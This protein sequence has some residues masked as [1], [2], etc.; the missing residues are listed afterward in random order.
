MVVRLV[1]MFTTY[2]THGHRQIDRKEET[3]LHN[4]HLTIFLGVCL[5]F[6]PIQLFIN[7]G[8]FVFLL[9]VLYAIFLRRLGM[10]TSTSV[11][12]WIERAMWFCLGFCPS[13]G[14]LGSKLLDLLQ[15]YSHSV[16]ERAAW[17]DKLW[18]NKINKTL[19]QVLSIQVSCK[20]LPW[21]ETLFWVMIRL[22]LQNR[23]KL[24]RE[25]IDI[26]TKP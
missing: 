23:A 7:C 21:I 18:Y 10:K 20:F 2:L 14:T 24:K 17:D 9:H 26:W 19:N 1:S 16:N 12:S 22:V 25:S 8:S 6:V 4:R 3:A 11:P 15:K 13:V 5:L